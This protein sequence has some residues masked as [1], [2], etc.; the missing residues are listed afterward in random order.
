[1]SLLEHGPPMG[2]WLRRTALAGVLVLVGC[3]AARDQRP[4]AQTARVQPSPAVRTTAV[5]ASPAPTRAQAHPGRAAS[6]NKPSG[7]LR[8]G[9][10]TSFAALK[11]Q[12]QGE[13]RVSVA[14][15][16]LGVGRPAVLGGDPAML[17]MSTTKVLILA[18]LLRDRGGVSGLSSSE[19]A[20]AS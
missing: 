7:P 14:V 18:A 3:G 4:A 2:G 5:P 17:G 10:T 8:A 15:Q 20:L 19:R 13:A 6:S 16:P 9:V 1:M 11:R 12:L